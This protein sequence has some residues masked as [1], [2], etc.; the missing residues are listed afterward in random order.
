VVERHDAALIRR[1][2]CYQANTSAKA[3][4]DLDGLIELETEAPDT[5]ATLMLAGHSRFRTLFLGGCCGT[6]ARHIEALARRMRAMA[7]DGRQ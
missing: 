3:P 5:L 1:I 2:V 4:Q 7:S 6:D